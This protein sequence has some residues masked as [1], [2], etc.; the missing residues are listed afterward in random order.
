MNPV[1]GHNYYMRA[2]WQARPETPEALAARFLRHIDL[3]REID[4]LFGLWL[5]GVKGPRKL[6]MIRDSYAKIVEA[7]ISRDDWGEPLPIDGYWF[8][9][10]TRGHP[11]PLSYAVRIHAGA[12]K[13]T[14]EFQNDA[15]LSTSTGFIPDPAAITYRIFKSALLAMVEAWAPMDCLALPHEL[16]DRI[17]KDQG[18]FREV[19]MQYLSAPLARLIVPPQTAVIDHL[20]DGGLLMSATTETFKVDNPAH[21]SVA[22]DIAAAMRPLNTLP[23]VRG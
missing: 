19:W 14:R 8:G 10:I 21:L 16:L 2:S 20:P 11:R 5:S 1:Y 3:L 9:A 13:H 23:Y 22:R 17:D 7:R 18:H 6:E 15:Y 4:P 12:D